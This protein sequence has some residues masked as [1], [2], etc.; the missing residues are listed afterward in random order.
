MV[1]L[2]GDTR[3]RVSP[4]AEPHT[5]RAL[6][7]PSKLRIVLGHGWFVVIDAH[8]SRAIRRLASFLVYNWLLTNDVFERGEVRLHPLYLALS[9][10][11]CIVIWRSGAHLRR[12]HWIQSYSRRVEVEVGRLAIIVAHV[13]DASFDHRL[14]RIW[15]LG[16]V[17]LLTSIRVHTILTKILKLPQAAPSRRLL[18]YF[19]L[20]DTV[21]LVSDWCGRVLVLW[22]RRSQLRRW[23]P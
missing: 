12:C 20:F 2:R 7:V 13:Y 8:D 10:G 17:H 23:R 6:C 16:L 9:N 21:L 18:T 15:N 14:L 4:V 11:C 5:D 1:L 19:S 22:R 3:N